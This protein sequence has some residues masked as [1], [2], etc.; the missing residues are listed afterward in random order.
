MTYA[1]AGTRFPNFSN[2]SAAAPVR[3]GSADLRG[4]LARCLHKGTLSVWQPLDFCHSSV[5]KAIGRWED[6]SRDAKANEFLHEM[7]GGSHNFNLLT[8]PSIRPS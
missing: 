2:I 5:V 8:D 1:A 6:F 7:E 4:L 3:R